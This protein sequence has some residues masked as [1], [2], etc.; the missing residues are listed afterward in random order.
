MGKRLFSV[1]FILKNKNQARKMQESQRLS[2]LVI[3][4]YWLIMM[5]INM[6]KILN[7]FAKRFLENNRGLVL[8]SGA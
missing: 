8:S 7:R 3:K 6:A 2:T 1:I 5:G 4:N